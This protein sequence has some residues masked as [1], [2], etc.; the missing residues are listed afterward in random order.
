MKTGRRFGKLSRSEKE[1]LE[2]VLL[3][4]MERQVWYAV[5]YSAILDVEVLIVL[6]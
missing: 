5:S 1:Y 3:D 6:Q 4:E 2:M